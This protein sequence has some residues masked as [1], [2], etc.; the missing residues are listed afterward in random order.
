[1]PI[2][3]WNGK[4]RSGEKRAGELEAASTDAVALHLK[5]MGIVPG[6]VK[7]KSVELPEAV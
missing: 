4:T 6:K 2:Y 1:M 5:N 7:A 3:L